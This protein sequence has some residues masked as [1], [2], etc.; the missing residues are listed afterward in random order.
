MQGEMT[1]ERVKRV[2]IIQSFAGLKS[3]NFPQDQQQRELCVYIYV[4][5]CL[6]CRN[7]VELNM[8]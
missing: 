2:Q 3:S 4:L 6:H 5:K 1:L 7:G 8:L